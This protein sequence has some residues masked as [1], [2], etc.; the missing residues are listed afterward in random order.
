MIVD[1]HVQR[2]QCQLGGW[3]IAELPWRIEFAALHIC[4]PKA[5][6]TKSASGGLLIKTIVLTNF[7]CISEILIAKKL[8]N[9]FTFFNAIS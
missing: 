9:Y 4:L 2:S 7:V 8:T 3:S 1:Q 6:Q 5:E